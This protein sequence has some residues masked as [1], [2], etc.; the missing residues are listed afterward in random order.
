[1]KTASLLL[2]A[3]VC[4]AIAS[5]Q[6]EPTLKPNLANVVNMGAAK[7]A[8]KLS[9]EDMAG[10]QKNL[11]VVTPADDWQLPP[12]YATNDYLNFSSLITTDGVLQLYHVFFDSTLRHAEENHLFQDLKKLSSGMLKQAK[13]RYASVKGTPLALAAVKNI[14]YFGVAS[15][16]L[17]GTEPISGAAQPMVA[18]EM[19]AIAG[20]NG[21]SA[22]AIFPSKIDYS[23]F[24]VRGHYTRSPVLQR[25]FRAMMWY[26]L[27]PFEME[28]KARSGAL[29]PN[30]EQVRQ[31]ALLV[32]DLYDSGDTKLWNQIY[33]VSALYVGDS[34]DLKP[35]EFRDVVQPIIGWPERLSMLSDD[36]TL[37]KM[38]AGLK[39]ASHAKIVNKGKDGTALGRGSVPIYGAAG[40]SGQHWCSTA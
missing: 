33:Q 26:G 13:M 4:V 18:K 16:I 38:V 40:D 35:S 23:Q 1:M 31:A 10:L 15:R 24:I 34:N 7:K 21:P 27:A 2:T 30:D 12:I 3:C 36:S 28:R 9:A 29:V 25:Y 17:G 32:Q 20:A 11:F 6:T 22:S 39:K 5:A 8:L 37:V 19:A 14:A